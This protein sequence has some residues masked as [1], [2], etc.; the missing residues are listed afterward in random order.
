VLPVFLLG[1]LSVQIRT[2][3]G[4][5][6]SRI[7]FAAAT[8]FTGAAIG[9]FGLRWTP[10]RFGA[11]RML[12]LTTAGSSL[13]MLL[14]AATAD[15]WLTLTVLEAVAG[16]SDG[17]LQPSA[18]LNLSQR[19]HT[20]KQATAYG[21][22]QASVPAATLLGGLAVPAIA[23]TVG[24]QWA[25]AGAGLFGLVLSGELLL[26]HRRLA[27][28]RLTSEGPAHRGL[29]RWG[30]GRWGLGPRRARR[31]DEAAGLGVP[32]EQAMNP[33][34]RQPIQRG[35][36]ASAGA[37]K[38]GGV[39]WDLVIPLAL[40]AGLAAGAANALGAFLVAGAVERH[41]S[42]GSAG[43]LFA[44]ASAS[45]LAAR[46]LAGVLADRHQFR[47]FLVVSAMLL[48]GS[49]GY[50]GLV[51]AQGWWIMPAALVSFSAAWGW[52]GLFNYGV[53]RAHPGSEA[54][55]TGFTQGGVFVGS[56]IGPLT[57]GLVAVHV[58]Y[59]AGWAG[60]A[61]AAIIAGVLMAVTAGEMKRGQPKNG[62]A[63]I[64]T[65]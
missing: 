54:S 9:S 5:D 43:V 8:F 34:P 24:W 58:S 15:K 16:F 25:F 51:F 48:V 35:S 28:G 13:A 27:Q 14:I 21:I 47:V 1:A 30:L 19:V 60:C 23:L 39:Q 29:A 32:L 11:L 37:K 63:A 44:L 6:E 22:K 18:N 42:P 31:A 36:T 62:T 59:A 41:I 40:G 64:E 17:I 33:A 57:F 56:I 45:S 26:A 52:N 38:A 53:A 12:A 4:V 20:A 46:L 3:L 49:L 61:G 2:T 65:N 55:A 10:E 50:L 7:G